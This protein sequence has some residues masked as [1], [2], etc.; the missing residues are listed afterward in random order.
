MP[1]LGRAKQRLGAGLGSG[2]TAGEGTQN[3]LCAYMAIS[4]LVGLLANTVLGAWWLDPVIALLIAVLAVREG[5]EAWEGQSCTCI[6]I[7]DVDDPSRAATRAAAAGHLARCPASAEARAG[8]IAAHQAPHGRHQLRGVSVAI[9]LLGA[10]HA[11]GDVTV[12]S[13]SATL[14]S[15]A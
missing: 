10:E 9:T 1:P 8:L 12:S 6:A 3:L 5:R 7:P 14:S 11:V 15:A 13:P 4:V 2:A